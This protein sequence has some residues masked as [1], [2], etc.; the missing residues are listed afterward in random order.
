MSGTERESWFEAMFVHDFCEEC[1]TSGDERENFLIRF[2]KDS[3]EEVPIEFAIQIAKRRNEDLC[4]LFG[5]TCKKFDGYER[6]RLSTADAAPSKSKA[7][8]ARKDPQLKTLTSTKSTG[9]AAGD[10]SNPCGHDHS[11]ASNYKEVL[12]DYY[13]LEGRRF[14]NCICRGCKK[15]FRADSGKEN[16]SI[17]LPKGGRNVCYACL[18]FERGRVDCQ[19]M[20]CQACYLA[21][22]SNCKRTRRS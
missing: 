3:P 17:S 19:N 21:S 14:A 22:S 8:K 18:H 9:G 12:D 15:P 11:S 6:K 1:V 13:F 5:G 7:K 2:M 10:A 16:N 4:E 20:L